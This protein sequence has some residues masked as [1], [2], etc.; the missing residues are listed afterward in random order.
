MLLDG[1]T[2]GILT[3]L[4]VVFL[5][6]KFPIGLRAFITRHSLASDILMAICTYWILGGTATALFAAAWVGIFISGL[7]YVNSHPA[8]FEFLIGVKQAV[9]STLTKLRDYLQE[10]NSAYLRRQQTVEEKQ[11]ASIPTC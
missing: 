2:L 5:Y 6:N 3:T 4:G 1:L 10:L 9:I 8:D 11:V 7:L